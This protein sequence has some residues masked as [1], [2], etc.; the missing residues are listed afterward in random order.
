MKLFSNTT[1]LIFCVIASLEILC[2]QAAAQPAKAAEPKKQSNAQKEAPAGESQLTIYSARNEQ[3]IQPVFDAYT[4]ETGVKISFLTDKEGALLEKLKAEGANTPA[5]LLITV[6]AG[7]L[8]YAAQQGIFTP[9]ESKVI[10]KNI[11]AHLRDPNNLWT[12][13]SVRA[14]TVFYNPKKVKPEELSTYEDLATAKWKK[15]LC[16]RT[17]K[18]VYNQS[19][20]AMLTKDFGAPKTSEIVSGWVSNLA[21]PVYPD[22]TQLLEAID[23][24]VCDVGIANT[25]YFG[26]LKEKNPKIQVNLFW[27]NQDAK[28]V[29]VNV[30]GAGIIK[31]SKNQKLALGFL[32]WLTSDKA[33]SIFANVNFEY[34][35][36][37]SIPADPSVAKWGAFKQNTINVSTA[38]ELQSEAIKLMDK[39]GYK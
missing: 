12:G 26:R 19:L 3:L 25:Y 34:P 36:N 35:A 32:E 5:D 1:G 27:P 4:K 13:L 6:D 23:A 37:S 21:K 14:R 10:E 24:G 38:G 16:L 33:Q 11:P 39:V 15:R 31:A 2:V 22:D 8:W 9:F 17:A 18:K 7:N 29:H 28:G 30:S 20:V